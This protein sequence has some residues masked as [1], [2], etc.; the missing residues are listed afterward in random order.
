MLRETASAARRDIMR[1][2]CAGVDPAFCLA[3]RQALEDCLRMYRHKLKG[4]SVLEI[5]VRRE[6]RA[7]YMAQFA[8]RVDAISAVSR[9][10]VAQI[11]D[12]RAGA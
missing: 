9:A 12:G 7:Y 4:L 11:R 1:A 6:R 8:S 5:G 10:Y 2:R 3:A